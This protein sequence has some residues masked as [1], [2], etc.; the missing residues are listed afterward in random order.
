MSVVV[1]ASAV[2]AFLKF[3]P[4]AEVVTEYLQGA[5]LSAVNLLEVLEKSVKIEPGAAEK[6]VRLLLGWQVE[7]VPFDSDQALIAATIRQQVGTA[8]VSLADRVCLAL[9]KSRGLPVVT[10][11]RLWTTLPLGLNVIQIRESTH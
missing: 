3:E 7:F 2:L 10:A 1:D 5:L 4:G 11:D 6:T 8:D 9:A